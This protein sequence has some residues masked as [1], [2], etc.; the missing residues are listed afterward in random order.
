MKK[1]REKKKQL[2]KKENNG[3]SKKPEP[4]T[5]GSNSTENKRVYLGNLSFKID[6]DGIREAFKDCGK[7]IA[8]DWVNNRETGRF[9]GTGFVEFETSEAAQKALGKNGTDLMGRSMKVEIAK[10]KADRG[11]GNKS[12]GGG[13]GGR[14]GAD[15][16]LSEK[17]DGCRTIFAGKLSY[18]IDEDTIRDTFKDC[19]DIKE[20][21]WLN[22]KQ[23]GEFK[24]CGFIEFTSA[25]A[26]DK[27][28][29]LQGQQVMGRGMRLDY[30][31]N[32]RE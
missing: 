30:A 6:D 22:D 32:K 10:P 26:V 11:F 9:T 24:G 5:N 12:G 14:G 21:R 7:L 20:I 8:I 25:E 19:G 17:P 13:G 2:K 23:S 29:L 18:S 28:I 4:K 3:K 27:A 15:N 31:Q 1:K 16:S